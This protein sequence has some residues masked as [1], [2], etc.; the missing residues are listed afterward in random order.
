M[1]KHLNSVITGDCLDILPAHIPDSSIDLVVTSPP[2]NVGIDYGPTCDDWRPWDKYYAWL[3]EV[4]QELYRTLKPGGVLALDLPKEVKLTRPEIQEGRKR[5]EKVAMK[6]EAIC[7]SLGYLPRESIV[8]AKGPEGLPVCSTNK[9]G[10]DNNIYLR[11][12]NHLIL[13]YS[14][15]RYFVEGGTGRRGKD[16]VPW[17]EETKDTWWIPAAHAN[18]HPCPFPEEVPRRL[19]ELFS[20]PRPEK[21]F[22]PL[23]LDPFAGAGTVGVTARRLGRN[24]IGVEINPDWATK[25]TEKIK[26]TAPVANSPTVAEVSPSGNTILRLPVDSIVVD[27]AFNVRATLDEATVEHYAGIFDQLPPVSVFSMP[28]GYLLV[29]GFHRMAAARRLGRTE[30]KA[31]VR[32]GS[33]QEAEE[34]AVLDNTTHGRPYSRAERR[35][36]ALRL[37]RLHPDWA[38]NR[39]A[40]KLGVSANTVEVIRQQAESAGQI[41]VME[42]LIGADGKNYPRS[43]GTR[44]AGDPAN[45]GA[46]SSSGAINGA[47]PVYG[48]GQQQGSQ[49]DNLPVPASRV[50]SG[51][52]EGGGLFAGIGT[53][54]TNGSAPGDGD[55]SEPGSQI[56]NLPTNINQQMVLLPEEYDSGP[57][58]AWS[59]VQADL[60]EWARNYDGP[61]FHTVL[62]DPPY[63]LEFLNLKWDKPDKA[64][65]DAELSQMQ[66]YQRWVT[67]WASALAENVLYPGAV[68]LFFGGTRT[69]HRL[70]AGLEDAGY[71]IF[72]TMMWLY[73]Q[74]MGKGM[75]ISKALDGAAFIDWLDGVDHGLPPADVRLVRSAAIQGGLSFEER[76]ETKFPKRNDTTALPIRNYNANEMNRGREMLADLIAR[77]WDGPAGTLPPGVRMKPANGERVEPAAPEAN[78]WQGYNTGL[79][80]AWEPIIVCRA[81]RQGRGLL[82]LVQQYGTAAL[83]IDAGRIAISKDSTNGSVWGSSNADNKP[84][85][86]GSPTGREYRSRQHPQGRWP[87]NTL[88]AHVPGEVCPHCAGTGQVSWEQW[89]SRTKEYGG[90]REEWERLTG[91]AET[92]ECGQCQGHGEIGGCQPRGLTSIKGITGTLNGSWRRGHQY[93]VGYS[94]ADETDLGQA[95]GYANADGTETVEA[96][97]CVCGCDDCGTEWPAETLSDCPACG[98]TSTGWRCPVRLLDDQAGELK[99][100]NNNICR[101][102]REKGWSGWSDKLVGQA[103]VSYGDSGTASRFFY[104]GKVARWEAHAGVKHL[105]WRN[106][107]DSTTGYSPVDA[108][109]WANLSHTD[110]GRG[111]IHVTRKPARLTEYLA[112]LIIPPNNPRILI[113]F[114]GSG[115]DG[116]GTMLAAKRLRVAAEIVGIERETQYCHIAEERMRWWAQFSNYDDAK[117]HWKNIR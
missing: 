46:G 45:G 20:R 43:T 99:S 31:E 40:G 11:A 112:G 88:L 117:K 19:I 82:E 80:P 3:K 60:L 70:A 94:G 44:E 96:W 4:L 97:A 36:A 42:T 54:V 61:R 75:D 105:Y 56:E 115:G 63:G 116:I 5:V 49:T 81:P 2:F 18:G 77:H 108:E 34:F 14:K 87:A 35:E 48:T 104:V 89:H 29:A 16:D 101:E 57:D 22:V 25:A 12:T 52:D 109:T 17:L 65:P 114:F 107:S 38:N 62:S 39:L 100:G 86:N 98:S 73:G 47:D 76:H 58:I 13:L 50:S 68:C 92:I 32:Q 24:F 103:R 1:E 71:E 59:V 113:P 74:G 78:D 66:A 51:P 26:A 64:N 28:E 10:S 90:S 67:D 41:E 6:V 111:N 23:V 69:F 21:G 83:N 33:R 93:N 30:V 91:G 95:I 15:E 9:S 27:P 8:W 55:G 37:L 7:D 102:S 53:A 110:R 79:K 72:D 84:K 85:F 106:D